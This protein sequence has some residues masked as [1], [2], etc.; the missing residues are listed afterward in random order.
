MLILGSKSPRRKEIL[1]YFSLPFRQESSDYDER[2]IPF[3][4]D[5]K[6][7]AC[8]IAEKKAESL[9]DRF[10]DQILIT[11]DT[12]VFCKNK[13]FH[14]PETEEEAIKML[15]ELSGSWH[16]V[17]TA[18]CVRKGNQFFTEAEETKI[19]LHSLT[20][21]Q[22]KSYHQ[23]FYFADKAGGYAI[24]E[25]GAI[26][27]KKIEGCFYNVMGLPITTLRT[28]LLEVGVDLWDFLK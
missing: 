16:Q 28:L 27:V 11:A 4:G 21:K 22:I 1:S 8:T 2:L 6:K 12:I 26:V 3:D 19:L 15:F 17:F 14:K 5:P 18:V 25:A 20:E 10:P 24:Q 13:I 7:Y 23:H 9:I